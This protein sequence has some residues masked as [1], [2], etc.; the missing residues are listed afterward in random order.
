ME[1]ETMQKA[2]TLYEQSRKSKKNYYEKNADK[3]K[4]YGRNYWKRVKEDPEK[5]KLYLEK[6]KTQYQKKIA[7]E[8]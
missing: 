8:L 4:E 5:Y 3:L 1:T 6:K 7:A 2:M